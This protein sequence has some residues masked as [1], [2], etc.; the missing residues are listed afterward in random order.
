M[1]LNIKKVYNGEFKMINRLSFT[2]IEVQVENY[3]IRTLHPS[4]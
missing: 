3:G 1:Y 4:K 2:D